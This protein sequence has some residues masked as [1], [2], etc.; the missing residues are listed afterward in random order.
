VLRETFPFSKRNILLNLKPTREPQLKFSWIY[1]RFFICKALLLAFRLVLGEKYKNVGQLRREYILFKNKFEN[2]TVKMSKRSGLSTAAGRKLINQVTGIV[3]S[4]VECSP[5]TRTTRVR[6]PDNATL[7]YLFF[8][9]NL[10]QIRARRRRQ[11]ECN[12]LCKFVQ[13]SERH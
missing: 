8:C 12:E 13:V 2:E 11:V 3:G 4:V 1:L 10:V 5:A 9:K 6:F 7:E